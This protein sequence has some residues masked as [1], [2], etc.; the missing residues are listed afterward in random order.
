M[1]HEVIRLRTYCAFG[2]VEVWGLRSDRQPQFAPRTEKLSNKHSSEV[3]PPFRRAPGRKGALIR[4]QFH[5]LPSRLFYSSHP[6]ELGADQS[7]GPRHGCFLAS[8]QPSSISFK[9]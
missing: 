6:S 4:Y 1:P 3:V 7:K 9:A 2:A 8:A 5:W